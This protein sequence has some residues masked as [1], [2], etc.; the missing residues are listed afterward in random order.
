M[1]GYPYQLYRPAAGNCEASIEVVGEGMVTAVP[2][3]A[4]VVL[5]A[6]TEGMELQKVQADNAAVMNAVIQALIEQN[7]AREKIQTSDYRIEV[8]YDYEQGR[9][10]FRG[11]RVTHLLQVIVDRV[12][13]TGRIV[14]TAVAHGANTVT[15]IQFATSM[16][17]LYEN[18]ALTEAIRSAR[19]KASTIAASLGLPPP[20]APC[21]IQELTLSSPPVPFK[22]AALQEAGGTPI[23][24]GE[25]N[26]YASVKVWFPLP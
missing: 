13:E 26:I 11:Y 21:K 3:R 20:A 23:Q 10:V 19:E 15:S 25:L 12:E 14:D 24:P 9:Q 18:K 7:I 1:Y 4:T 6:V 8:L 5:G 2:D 17:Q 22:M 16:Q